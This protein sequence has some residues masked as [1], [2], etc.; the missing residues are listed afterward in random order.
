MISN[1]I[2]GSWDAVDDNQIFSIRI[3]TITGDSIFKYWDA[4]G[5]AGFVVGPESARTLIPP[6]PRKRNKAPARIQV[7]RLMI[8][9]R[10]GF[11]PAQTPG[12]ARLYGSRC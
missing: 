6:R 12:R 1:R 4:R 7:I 11:Y 8:P 10:R 9:S 5:A 2:S 3:G